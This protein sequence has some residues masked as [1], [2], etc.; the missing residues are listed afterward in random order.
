MKK[1]ILI[2][3]LSI[4]AIAAQAQALEQQDNL[5]DA[6][7][8]DYD[9]GRF[10]EAINLL[11]D[12]VKNFRG[13][14]RQTA[15]KLLSLSYLA[16]DDKVEAERYAR[17]LLHENPYYTTTMQ[18]PLRFNDIVNSIKAGMTATITT[19]S[20]QAESI[21]ESPVPITLITE[22]M[23][24]DCGGRNLKEVL[25][26]YVPGMTDV[27]NNGDVNV[28]MRGVF[29]SGQEK[30]L[31]ML[32]G[33]RLNSY[34]TNTGAPDF[35]MSL[36][37]IKQIEVLR[38]PSS[39]LY[40]GVALTAVI[41]II[42]KSGQDIDGVQLRGGLGNYGQR[43]GDII[44]G[45]TYYDINIMV[46]GSIYRA[47]GQPAY[48]DAAETGLHLYDGNYLIGAFR[49]GPSY[50]LG[51]TIR[52]K[53]FS[54]LYNSRCSKVVPSLTASYTFSPYDYEKYT[55]YR[56]QEVG[57]GTKTHHAEVGYNNTFGRW[58]VGASITYDVSDLTHY[59]VLSENAFPKLGTIMGLDT[60]YNAP[61][62]NNGVYRYHDAQESNIGALLKAD[63]NYINNGTHNGTISFG[64]HYNRFELEDTRYFI[65]YKYDQVLKEVGLIKELGKGVEHGADAYLQ[66]KHRW[67]NWIL[68][69]GL[70]YDYKQY[71][72]DKKINELSPRA[73]I[74]YVGNKWNAKINFSRSFVDAPY[75]YRRTNYVLG[76]YMTPTTA[77][78]IDLL[79][80]KLYSWQVSFGSDKLV[81]GLNFEVNTFFNYA[82]NLIFPSGLFHSN[83]ASGKNLGVE[84]TADYRRNRL[85][86]HLTFT[87]QK[88]IE[89]DYNLGAED[90]QPNVPEISANL[91]TAYQLLRRLRLHGHLC[92]YGKQK[93]FTV[94]VTSPTDRVTFG[95][96]A[97]RAIVNLGAEYDLKP[98]S[99]GFDI[100]NLFNTTYTQ[101]G[102]TAGN[103]RQQGLW[104]M[105]YASY[106]F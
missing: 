33:H 80:E 86:S 7:Q 71:S 64:A 22:E 66:M 89:V 82:K 44:F 87:W 13:E 103:L 39:S 3:L 26:A 99:V 88:T 83:A 74:V 69:V 31:I 106:K 55:T 51:V 61:L 23:I 15:Y 18:D 27:D 56:G 72:D 94:N 77:T 90:F 78:S 45:K 57:I 30:M 48:I 70:R 63:Y 100:H 68:N 35:S 93:T 11:E 85:T 16:L 42:T 73:A 29:S 4:V 43:R 34:A 92:F 12:S 38:G 1:L 20:S 67:R 28:A 53:E 2:C 54:F 97:A 25:M 24:R 91:V 10:E 76:L 84:I 101:G 59:Q 96:N 95:T 102:L 46:W 21:D 104:F 50:D 32:N 19:A 14:Y 41:N 65:G 36:E 75:F 81:P 6:A 37:K 105:A 52:W 47:G 62:N 49:G 5:C 9:I 79:P 40:G 60:A 17:L 8:A 98:F 58:G